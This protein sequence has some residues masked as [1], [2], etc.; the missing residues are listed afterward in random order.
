MTEP[1]TKP[2]ETP[3]QD[4]QSL[5]D[6]IKVELRDRDGNVKDTRTEES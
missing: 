1:D 4:D 3:G 2:E 6:T 5:V